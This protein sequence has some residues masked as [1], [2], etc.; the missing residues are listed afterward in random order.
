V[1]VFGCDGG[2]DDDND[3]DGGGCDGGV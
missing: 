1:A 3:G 2:D